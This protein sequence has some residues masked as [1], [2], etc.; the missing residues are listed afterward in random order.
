MTVKDSFTFDD[1][2]LTQDRDL[3]MANLHVD[4]LFI[5]IPLDESVDIWIKKLLKTPETLVEVISK[6][7][8]RDLLNLATK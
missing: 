5:N 1:E 6:N 3:C 8:F 2:I 4:A 7:D